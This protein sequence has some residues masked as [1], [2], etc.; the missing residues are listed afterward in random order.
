[1]HAKELLFYANQAKSINEKY[2][3]KHIAL[4]GEQVAAFGDNPKTVWLEAKK[5]FPN[6]QPVLAFVPKHDTLVLVLHFG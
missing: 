2:E 5:K 4:V 1:M 3:G 6:K